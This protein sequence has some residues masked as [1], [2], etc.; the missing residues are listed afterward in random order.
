MC[1]KNIYS[2]NEKKVIRRWKK[3]N[4]TSIPHSFTWFSFSRKPKNLLYHVTIY[5]GYVIN[6]LYY[7]EICFFY[8]N[9]DE[10]YHHEWML[11]FVKCLFCIYWNSYVI[12][13]LSF[14]N[15]VYHI[16]W[17]ASIESFLHPW[18]KSHLIMGYDPFHILLNSDCLYFVSKVW[19]TSNNFHCSD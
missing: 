8:I 5:S 6:D 4:T 13:I 12:S 9:F 2:G 10:S 11:N 1:S 3:S 19:A 17:L 18:N 15:V 7:I 16:D 14:D